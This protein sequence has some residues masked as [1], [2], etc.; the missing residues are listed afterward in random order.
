MIKPLLFFLFMM[1]ITI[2]T[3]VVMGQAEEKTFTNAKFGI[4][5]KYP[6]DWTFVPEE[7]DLV[8]FGDIVKGTREFTVQLDNDSR[9][10]LLDTDDFAKIILEVYQEDND[11]KVT[12]NF[13][14]INIDGEP[15]K[16]FSYSEND[17]EI[18]VA[19][20]MHENIPFL[21]K[22]ETLEENFEK[23]TD[24]MMHFFSSVRFLEPTAIE[25]REV[26]TSSEPKVTIS[27]SC[28]PTKGFIITVTAYGFKPYTTVNWK[29]VNSDELIP[30]YGYF[31]TNNEG[32]LNDI[33][34][35]DDLEKD[36]YKIYFGEDVDNDGRIDSS[37]ATIYAE[38]NIPCT[39]S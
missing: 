37:S 4:S 5:M 20:L 13:G 11:V 38:L 28:G 1:L 26:I 2:G 22:Y 35:L 25:D 12:N 24:T 23:D 21:F 14:E 34:R 39:E 8:L 17:K 27:P 10:S 16:T 9:L 6:S 15:A 31:S 33:V 29:L 3:N 36:S 32:Q 7:E 30:L 19:A 18:M